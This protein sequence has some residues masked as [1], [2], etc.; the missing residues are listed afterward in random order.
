MSRGEREQIR[1]ILHD[2][3]ARLRDI[4]DREAITTLIVHYARACDRG[5]DPSLLERLFTEDAV[6]ECEGFGR[7]EGRARL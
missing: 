6:W 2:L 4:E 1:D 5:N 3:D 7:Y